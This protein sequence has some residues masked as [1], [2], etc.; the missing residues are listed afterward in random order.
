MS[1]AEIILS[2]VTMLLGGCN[3][4]QLLQVRSLRRKASAEA[5]QSEIASLKLIIEG[6]VAEIQRLQDRINYYVTLYDGIVDRYNELRLRV[7]PE[8]QPLCRP[9]ETTTKK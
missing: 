4:M 9:S 2:V 5:Y 8:L 3:I 6:N 7:D 1:I